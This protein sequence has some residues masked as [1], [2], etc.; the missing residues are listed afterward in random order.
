M[1][2][3]AALYDKELGELLAPICESFSLNPN[4]MI[5]VLKPETVLPAYMKL[6]STIHPLSDGRAVIGWEGVGA[7]EF[8]VQGGEISVRMTQET[9]QD[10]LSQI[11]FHQLIFGYN[12]F[13]APKVKAEIPENWFPLPVHIPDPDSF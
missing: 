3:S 8:C 4:I 9:P 6:K 13:A 5:R 7:L 10:M 2:I 12:R 11:E 1:E